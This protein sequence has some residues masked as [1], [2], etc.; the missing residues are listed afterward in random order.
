MKYWWGVQW[1]MPG[2]LS[3]LFDWW[4][5]YKYKNLEAKTW[6]AVLL[7]ALWSIWKHRNKCKFR[8]KQSNLEN[9]N[10]LIK[11]RVAIWVK[12]NARRLYYSVQDFVSDFAQIKT[13]AKAIRY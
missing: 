1:V 13:S 2:S 10:E 11:I 3:G 5:G 9:L 8:E 12:S 4:A 7:A 6:K